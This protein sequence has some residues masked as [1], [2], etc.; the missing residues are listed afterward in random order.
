VNIQNPL[1]S[2]LK[3]LLSNGQGLPAACG[4]DFLR[5]FEPTVG[6]CAENLHLS[7]IADGKHCEA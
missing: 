4:T 3:N 7:F 5:S 6:R 2:S 1:V